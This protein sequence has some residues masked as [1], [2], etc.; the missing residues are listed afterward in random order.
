MGGDA[1]PLSP[2]QRAISSHIKLCRPVFF[3][4]TLPACSVNGKESAIHRKTDLHTLLIELWHEK[5]PGLSANADAR[6]PSI[7]NGIHAL[8]MVTGW[9]LGWLLLGQGVFVC[10]RVC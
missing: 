4:L 8:K 1:A 6:C 9:M 7:A 2:P 5:C 3:M 10:V